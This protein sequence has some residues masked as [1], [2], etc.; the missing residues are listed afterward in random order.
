MG[1][2][3][4]I[5]PIYRLANRLATNDLNLGNILRHRS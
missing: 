2:L 5:L 4:T 3:S 1:A